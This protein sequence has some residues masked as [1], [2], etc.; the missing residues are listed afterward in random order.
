[1]RST[2]FLAFIELEMVFYNLENRQREG[3]FQIIL[4]ENVTLSR[5][6]VKIGKQPQEREMVEKPVV[7]YM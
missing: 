2:G 3:H 5:F 6:A 1:M 4:P 7:L